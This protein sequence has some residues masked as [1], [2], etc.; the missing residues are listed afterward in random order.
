MGVNSLEVSQME[1]QVALTHCIKQTENAMSSLG[2]Q[3]KKCVS[4][5]GFYEGGG[6]YDWTEGFYTGEL[7]LAY[8]MTGEE[9]FKVLALDH[10]DS[11]LERIEKRIGVDHHDMGFLY[12]L[13]CVAAYKL[14]GSEAG[15]QAALLAADNL[16]SR[17]HEKGE[18]IQ[19]WGTLG[20]PDNYRLIIDCLLNLPLLYW[21]TEVTEDKKYE[22]I[23]RKHI[24]TCLKHI[25]REDH[26]TY[27]TYY[28]DPETGDGV[29]GVT[30]Q[31]YRNGSAWARGQAWG[32]YGLALSYKY[33]KDESY[34]ELFRK[35]TDFF[36]Q[37][38][39]E[40][41]VPYWDFDFTDG[42]NEPRDSSSAA[43]A[44]CGM[45]EMSKYLEPEAALYYQSTAKKILKSL[46][47]NYSVK[48]T[49]ISNGQLLHGTYAKQSPYNTVQDNG[50]DECNVWGDY[51][52]VE[53]IVRLLKDWKSY[54]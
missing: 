53:A 49:K 24:Q 23:A 17:F 8:E 5:N 44:V 45:L 40:D 3:F 41:L 50:V 47:D 14:V 26:S 52:Y 29:R 36:I 39:P 22:E 32:V 33:I 11:F 21:A 27:H 1:L 19:A 25:V 28:F 2:K 46:I 43:I 30:A 31:G 38:L 16:I 4:H 54:W 10:V 48:D 9:K 12:S 18:F 51:Y 37:H 34:I 7:W 20:A 42:S 15:K 13:S 6:N 35:V